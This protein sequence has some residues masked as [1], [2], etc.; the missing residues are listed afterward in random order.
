MEGSMMTYL[1]SSFE[2]IANARMVFAG[3]IITL[4]VRILD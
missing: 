1:I 3:A 2:L 4:L